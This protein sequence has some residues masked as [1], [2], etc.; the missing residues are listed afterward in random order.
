MSDRI[1]VSLSQDLLGFMFNINS[2]TNIDQY[3]QESNKTY[4]VYYAQLYYQ[5]GN[6]SQYI[7]LDVIKCT[8]PQLQGYN[9]VDFSKIS[10]YSLV[11]DNS[12][13]LFSQILINVYG[14]LDVDSFKTTIPNNCASQKEIDDIINGNTSGLLLKMKVQQYNTTSKQIQTNYRNIFSFLQSSQFIITTLK[15]QKQETQVNEGLLFQSKQT[16]NS[17]IQYEQMSQNFDRQFSLEQGLGPYNQVSIYLDEIVQ[18]FQIQ[19]PT[20]TE[21][22]A[23]VNSVA[24]V[25]LASKFIDKNLQILKQNFLIDQNNEIQLSS[26]QTNEVFLDEISEKQNKLDLNIPC[27]NSK[28][29]DYVEKNQITHKKHEIFLQKGDDISVISEST[30]SCKNTN[31]HRSKTFQ[32]ESKIS[33]I[34]KLQQNDNSVKKYLEIKR[35]IFLKTKN[36][37]PFKLQKQSQN[38]LE[39]TDQVEISEKNVKKNS[40]FVETQIKNNLTQSQNQGS[41]REAIS[42]K[43]QAIYSNSMKNITQK[44]IFKSRLFKT[45]D[46]DAYKSIDTNTLA[47]I[48]K[49]VKKSLDIYEF[50]KDIIFLKKAVSMLLNKDQLA[51][52]QLVNLTDKF[53]NFNLN[54]ETLKTDYQS[55]KSQLNYFEKQFLILQS[56]QLQAQYIE[57]FFKKVHEQKQLIEVDKRI[58]QS[59]LNKQRIY[60]KYYVLFYYQQLLYKKHINSQNQMIYQ[61]QILKSKSFKSLKHYLVFLNNFKYL[62]KIKVQKIINSKI[63]IFLSDQFFIILG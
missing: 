40:L 10:N 48:S 59:I 16:Y 45:K 52:I 5:N 41:L 62:F 30:L 12:V 7:N 19:Y 11:L 46:S 26:Q 63:L 53:L 20:F 42:Q 8:D 33:I 60:S 18:Q 6:F 22:L 49:E 35:P 61:K 13:A 2:S 29:R 38:H 51:A 28:F 37:I 31:Q 43:L 44:L 32:N 47:Q 3:Q 36:Q 58:I 50:Y 25:I 9:C 55:A 17:P 14:C 21:I 54:N 23:L 56:E 39:K 24:L 57:K 15:T 1:D 34:D 27:F 4:L